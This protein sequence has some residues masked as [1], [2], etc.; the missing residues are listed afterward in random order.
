[1]IAT[2]SFF[3]GLV[4][5]KMWSYY[6]N[7]TIAQIQLLTSD[8]PLIVYKKKEKSDKPNKGDVNKAASE[9]CKKYAG[10]KAKGISINLSEFN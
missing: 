7:Y 4:H 6:W 9:W 3:F 8:T 5:V 2:K 1:M 10:N